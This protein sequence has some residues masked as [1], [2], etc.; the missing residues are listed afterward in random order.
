[1][2]MAC[3]SLFRVS[4]LF[5]GLSA[6]REAYLWLKAWRIIFY[7]IS[8]RVSALMPQGRQIENFSG[9]NICRGTM[10]IR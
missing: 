2:Q 6:A 9:I 5:C 4:H 3:L 8:G 1:M 7:H 10:A